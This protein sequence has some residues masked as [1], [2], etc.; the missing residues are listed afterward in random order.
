MADHHHHHGR[1]GHGHAPENFGVAFALGTALN[2]GFVLVEAVYGVLA[3]SMALI[4]DAG[5][6]FGDVLGLLMAWTASVLARRVPTRRYTYGLGRG[7]ILAALLNA[8]LL[9]IAVGAIAVEGV[10]RL[11]WPQPVGDITVMAVAGIGIAVNGATALL[12]A[13]GRRGDVNLRATF[14]HMAA[15]VLVS[16]G[17]VAAAV[18]IALTGWVRLDPIVSIAIAGVILAG[19][20]NVLGETLGLSLDAVPPGIRPEEVRG[21]LVGLPGVSR[22]HDLH[23]WPMSTT[24]T[25][26]TVHLVMPGERPGDRFIATVCE[27]LAHRFG[28]GHSTLQIELDDG[29]VCALEPDHVI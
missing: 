28:I 22:V 21:Y 5:H 23:I 9:L 7:T 15:D 13:R 6:N 8:A 4:A 17:V 25:A 3:H 20:W 1:A 2:S 24:E 14:L 16:A 26:L 18:V 27:E 11:I 29:V 12:F 10:R 19:T